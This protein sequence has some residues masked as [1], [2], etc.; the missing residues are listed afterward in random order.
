MNFCPGPHKL[1]WQACCWPYGEG[2]T[3][4]KIKERF[5]WHGMVKDMNELVN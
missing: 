3:I 1:C 4:H 5:M 2:K